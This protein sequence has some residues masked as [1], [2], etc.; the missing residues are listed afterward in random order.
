MRGAAGDGGSLESTL[1]SLHLK[2]WDFRAGNPLGLRW[3]GLGD[4]R[5][6]T[7]TGNRLQ[8]PRRLALRSKESLY[9]PVACKAP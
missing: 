9:L 2:V 3:S 4:G 5:L 6:F 1:I 8:H 7:P